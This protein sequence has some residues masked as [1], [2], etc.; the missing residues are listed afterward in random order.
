MVTTNVIDFTE[1]LIQKKNQNK[2]KRELLAA[3][4]DIGECAGAPDSDIV[5][6]L[7]D[8]ASDAALLFGCSADNLYAASLSPVAWNDF[9]Q[10]WHI[11]AD[12]AFACDRKHRE[13]TMEFAMSAVHGL[14]EWPALFGRALEVEPGHK[15]HIVLLID[16]NGARRPRHLILAQS[17]AAVLNSDSIRAIIDRYTS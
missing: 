9:L 1:R 8:G 13:I 5:M 2:A 11:V 7:V 14:D 16:R 17:N 4:W 6:Y 12:P 3:G 15:S 10:A